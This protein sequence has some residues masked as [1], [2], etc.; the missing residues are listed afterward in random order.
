MS[1]PAQQSLQRFSL[2]SPIATLI[3]TCLFAL[4]IVLTTDKATYVPVVVVDPPDFRPLPAEPTPPKKNLDPP[5]PKPLPPVTGREPLPVPPIPDDA[6]P[7]RETVFPDP[8]TLQNQGPAGLRLAR[9][10]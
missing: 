4:L 5:P 3:T 2:A 9:I 6:L 8:W 7:E 10:E 1:V